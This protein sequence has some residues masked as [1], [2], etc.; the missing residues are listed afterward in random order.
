MTEMYPILLLVGCAASI[1]Y[2]HDV[3]LPGTVLVLS[4]VDFHNAELWFT[5]NSAVL[6]GALGTFGSYLHRTP[7]ITDAERL[8][9][10]PLGPFDHYQHARKRTSNSD[11]FFLP[12]LTPLSLLIVLGVS[13][14]EGN[15]RYARKN[16]RMRHMP[17][18]HR[19]GARETSHQ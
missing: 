12:R 1:Q 4:S 10:A 14:A 8:V 3:L 15:L 16:L 6:D 11:K 5:R 19:Q 13:E 18:R 17:S 9:S 2:C 7:A